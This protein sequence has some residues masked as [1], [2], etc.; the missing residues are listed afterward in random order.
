M[1]SIR[2]PPLMVARQTKPYSL[3]LLSYCWWEYGFLSSQSL[4]AVTHR[5]SHSLVHGVEKG[6]SSGR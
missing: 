5:V 2:T 3:S 4:K 1:K 6:E